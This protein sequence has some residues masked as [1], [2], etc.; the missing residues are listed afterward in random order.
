MTGR[1]QWFT[2]NPTR[3]YGA[4]RRRGAPAETQTRQADPKMIR[5]VRL[6]TRSGSWFSPIPRHAA[7]GRSNNVSTY[8]CTNE[9]AFI[10]ACTCMYINA[11]CRCMGYFS[12]SPART[13]D[14]GVR[15]YPVHIYTRPYIAQVSPTC[16]H[17]AVRA[18]DALAVSQLFQ[19]IY[20]NLCSWYLQLCSCH[21]SYYQYWK[22]IDVKNKECERIR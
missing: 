3:I 18:Q 8:A 11:C 5:E 10:C 2:R 6:T 4:G 14:V 22:S 13:N 15:I 12:L 16:E 9:F 7:L 17:S 21:H 19:I 20:Q 1:D